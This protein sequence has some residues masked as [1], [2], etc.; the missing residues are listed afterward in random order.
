MIGWNLAWCRQCTYL[1]NESVRSGDNPLIQLIN[2]ATWSYEAISAREWEFPHLIY[3]FEIRLYSG[4]DDLQGVVSK[5]RNSSTIK[6]S[7]LWQ[8]N[9][10]FPVKLC[11]NSFITLVFGWNIQKSTSYLIHPECHTLFSWHIGIRR[12]FICNHDD[13]SS[14]IVTY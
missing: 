1:L 9:R 14:P 6:E 2:V 13:H 7:L 3:C 12:Q 8:S 4:A 5:Q 10:C 11:Y